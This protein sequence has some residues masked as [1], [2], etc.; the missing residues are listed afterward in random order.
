LPGRTGERSETI[1]SIGAAVFAVANV[2]LWGYYSG[3]WFQDIFSGITFIYLLVTSSQAVYRTGALHRDK[4]IIL[5]GIW[6]TFVAGQIGEPLLRN[7]GMILLGNIMAGFN[8]SLMFGTF[9]WLTVKVF[10]CIKRRERDQALALSFGLMCW[11]LCTLYMCAEPF[12]QL[13]LS[14]ETFQMVL[15][16]FIIERRVKTA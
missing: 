13:A 5:I 2:Y 4:W 12:Y 14:C 9:L 11:S 6:L 1:V 7:A 8:Y 10:R 16:W 3:A 15:M